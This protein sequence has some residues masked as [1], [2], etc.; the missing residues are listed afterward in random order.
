M[1]Q[2]L[3]QSPQ[4]IQAMQI[5]QLS[6]L[7]LLDRIQQELVENPFLEVEEGAAAAKDD[8]KAAQ[9]G[10]A[11]E[12]GSAEKTPQGATRAE[13]AAEA[14]PQGEADGLTG[15]PERLEPDSP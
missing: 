12:R 5:L 9:P 6:G 10:A 7:D 14:G 11:G 1:E 13:P 15:E 4:M 8:G 3:V 2:R